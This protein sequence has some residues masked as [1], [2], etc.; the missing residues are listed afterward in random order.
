MA[1]GANTITV[2]VTAQ[3]TTTVKTYTIV[4]TRAVNTPPV[5]VADT[6]VTT[7]NH[8]LNTSAPGVLANDTDVDGNTL[9]AIKVTDPAHGTLMLNSNGSYTYTPATGF[10]G[11][12][13]FTYKAN[14]SVVDSNVVIVAITVVDDTPPA[15]PAPPAPPSGGGG[16][17]GGFGGGAVVKKTTPGVADIASIID[18]KG[19]FTDGVTGLSE[20][21]QAVIRI[22]SGTTAAAADGAPF[23][24]IT[25][26]KQNEIDNLPKD[27]SIVGE[28]YDF[29]PTGVTFSPAVTIR[30]SYNPRNLPEGV[31]ESG[32]VIGYYDDKSGNWYSLDS[33]VDLTG[34]NV[35]TQTTHFSTYAILSGP[36]ATQ[37]LAAQVSAPVTPP[38]EPAVQTV[39][40]P[41]N[42]ATTPPASDVTWSTPAQTVSSVSPEDNAPATPAIPV[43]P[44]P[45]ISSTQ[46]VTTEAAITTTTTA[47][48]NTISGTTAG[49]EISA[50][51]HAGNKVP[52][53]VL[54]LT[55]VI[56]GMIGTVVFIRRS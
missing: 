3:D 13:S 20:D 32:L 35:Y 7:K 47:L 54:V 36:T 39:P 25:I 56:I 8:V 43:S 50:D 24:Q 31:S 4:V 15:P 44:E 45:L 2:A 28:T 9:T 22:E 12:D 10:V 27:V 51:V 29:G 16:G 38:V 11:T 1:V 33:T 18:A 6:G 49:T 26:K 14:D 53:F 5:A 17:G 21:N 19:L 55:S 23:S 30:L 34:R 42:I 37:P 46:P 40:M 41:M 48:D 52:L